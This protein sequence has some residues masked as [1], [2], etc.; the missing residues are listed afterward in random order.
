M[1]P[2][3]CIQLQL[4]GHLYLG[5][6]IHQ[7]FL[8]GMPGDKTP[9]KLIFRISVELLLYRKW[10]HSQVRHKT[11]TY[12]ADVIQKLNVIWIWSKGYSLVSSINTCLTFHQ[13]LIRHTNIQYQLTA[14]TDLFQNLNYVEEIS[15]IVP[16]SVSTLYSFHIVLTLYWKF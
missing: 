11:E 6:Q 12:K 4:K 13:C 10:Y 9:K 3:H 1:D 16:H 8:E 7:P 5:V 14:R 15:A 2:T